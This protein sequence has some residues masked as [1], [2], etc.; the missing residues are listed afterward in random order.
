MPPINKYECNKCGYSF[1]TGWGGHMYVLDENYERIVCMHPV[2]HFTVA[3]V[4]GD[5]ASKELIKSKTG[6]NSYCVC[7]DCLDLFVLDLGDDE[8]AESWR[9]YYKMTIQRD[10]RICP[11]CESRHVKTVL[12]M[13]GETCPKCKSA[14]EIFSRVVGYL[15]PVNQ[16]NKGKQE[17]FDKRKT[18]KI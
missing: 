10:E 6:Y 2:E 7:L 9:Y 11:N 18:L 16:W 15:R 8:K 3:Q 14:C 13:I 5:G 17:E 1:P 12:E 4:L